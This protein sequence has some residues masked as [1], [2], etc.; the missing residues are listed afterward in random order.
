MAVNEESSENSLTHSP[1]KG[2]PVTSSSLAMKAISAVKTKR[3]FWQGKKPIKDS[4]TLFETST[5][6]GM[7]WVPG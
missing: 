7:R 4:L 3:I 6:F 2:H 5:I 1:P